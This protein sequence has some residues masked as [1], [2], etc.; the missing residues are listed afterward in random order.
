MEDV[1]KVVFNFLYQLWLARNNAQ[2]YH[3]EDLA[4]FAAKAVKAPTLVEEWQNLKEKPFNHAK[5]K[6]RWHPPD[7]SRTRANT[8]GAFIVSDGTRGSGVVLWDHHV[9]EPKCVEHMPMRAL[10]LAGEV[11]VTRLVLETN[12][13]G[14]AAKLVLQE[15][16]RSSH[17]P[18][19]EEVNGLLHG[20]QE[21]ANKSIRRSANE[22]AH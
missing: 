18:Q 3:I 6:G 21:I 16:A 13:T 7:E 22:V 20:F 17:G 9:A 19:A 5:L 4:A 8:D 14:I 2:H 10:N 15:R 11:G 1:L 12:S